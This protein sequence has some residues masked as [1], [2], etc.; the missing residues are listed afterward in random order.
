MKLE[1]LKN[2]VTLELDPEKCIGC[3]RCVE[4]CPHGVFRLAGI[5]G[6]TGRETAEIIDKDSCMEC[7]A[8]KKNCPAG[9]I[10]AGAGVGCAAAII[11]G[12]L[13]KTAPACG[14]SET[15]RSGKGGSCCC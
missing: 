9:A 10:V 15:A 7:G 8:C 1:Y 12:M 11:Y 6:V 3:G 14:C 4:V 13:K 5:N 2:M